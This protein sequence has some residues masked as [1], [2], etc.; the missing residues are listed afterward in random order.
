MDHAH[1]TWDDGQVAMSHA[2]SSSVLTPYTQIYGYLGMVNPNDALL[3]NVR[4]Q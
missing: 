2:I 4:T 3:F 1:R